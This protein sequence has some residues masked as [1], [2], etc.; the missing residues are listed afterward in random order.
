MLVI[1]FDHLFNIRKTYCGKENKE[2]NQAPKEWERKVFRRHDS[3]VIS[4]QTTPELCATLVDEKFGGL[5][6]LCLF[7]S[8][9]SIH[10][11][12]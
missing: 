3:G 5:V 11:S 7:A 4:D 2:K 10:K 6:S 9:G 1:I 8:V 12:E